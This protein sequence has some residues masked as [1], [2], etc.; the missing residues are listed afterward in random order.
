MPT[1]NELDDLFWSHPPR[2]RKAGA[3]H[4]PGDVGRP[5]DRR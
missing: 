2:F 4:L 3:Y 5:S 1:D